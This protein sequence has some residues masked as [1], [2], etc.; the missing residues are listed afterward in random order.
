[1]YLAV[2]LFSLSSGL[3]LGSG[4]A[5]LLLVPLLGIFVRRTLKEDRMLHEELPGY[6]EYAT[7]V[8]WRVVP[9]I[10]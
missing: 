9:G 4:W 10:F 2:L 5:G 6:T 8:R 1:M 7:R 3:A